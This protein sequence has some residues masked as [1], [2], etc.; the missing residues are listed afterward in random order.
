MTDKPLLLSAI[1]GSKNAIAIMTLFSTDGYLAIEVEGDVE[2]GKQ[3]TRSQYSV[4]LYVADK[5]V[6]KSK[7]RSLLLK[8][9]WNADNEM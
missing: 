5:E 3:R 6:A 1:L 7:P 9:E 8:W 4:R 2:N